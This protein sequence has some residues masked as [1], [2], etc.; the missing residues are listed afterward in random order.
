MSD[1]CD[2]S[3]KKVC[4]GSSSVVSSPVTLCSQAA[5]LACPADPTP[6]SILV[7]R[8]FWVSR[9]SGG[10]QPRE[11]RPP[12]GTRPANRVTKAPSLIAD[13]P[14]AAQNLTQ[15]HTEPILAAIVAGNLPIVCRDTMTLA[16]KISGFLSTLCVGDRRPNMGRLWSGVFETVRRAQHSHGKA[17]STTKHA[18]APEERWRVKSG[19]G[20]RPARRQIRAEISPR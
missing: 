12:L 8:S 20:K 10:G 16:A 1:K 13:C 15:G 17:A 11:V 2:C 18:S 4:C 9:A 6:A 19:A 5:V 7:R 3:T 14:T